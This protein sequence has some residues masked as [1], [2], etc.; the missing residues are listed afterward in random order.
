MVVVVVAFRQQR[1]R[2]DGGAVAIA[3]TIASL[4]TPDRWLSWGAA[5]GGWS[6]MG[7]ICHPNSVT[8]RSL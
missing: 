7:A 4:V 5:H 3:R 1:T 6:G 8:N 2:R